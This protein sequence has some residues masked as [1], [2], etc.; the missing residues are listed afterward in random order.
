MSKYLLPILLI[1][2]ISLSCQGPKTE[3]A[4]LM[5]SLEKLPSV[6]LSINGNYSLA[7]DH[8]LVSDSGV[9]LKSIQLLQGFTSSIKTG[10]QI[11]CLE[12]PNGH[13]KYPYA[14][15]EQYLLEREGLQVTRL[16][17]I[18]QTKPGLTI[19]NFVKNVSNASV[20][21]GFQFGATSELKPSVMMDRTY[22]VNGADQ[23]IFDE[24]T[25]IFTA[26]DELNDWYAVW[27]SSADYVLAPV[28]LDCDAQASS[29][30]ASAGFEVK[31]E[32]APDQEQIVPVYIAGSDQ[33]EFAAMET[34]AELRTDLYTDWDMSFTLAD[35]LFSTSKIKVPDQEITDAYNWSKYKVGLFQFEA[36]DMI[37]SAIE[38]PDELYFL[39]KEMGSNF[40]HL[41]D[42]EVFN[43][44]ESKPRHIIPGWELFQP[45]TFYLL[46]IYG[47]I[48][49]RVTYIRPNLPSEWNDASIE[50][51]WID[52]NKLDIAIASE[53]NQMTVEITQSQ[54][55][56]GLS[57]ELPEEFSQVKVLGKEVST[58]TKDGY[59]RILMTGD[60]VRIEANKK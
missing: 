60:H 57:I 53:E 37:P 45:S 1:C 21:L 19:L 22:E 27:G 16:L 55:K 20:D 56:A 51:L 54:K 14:V 58:D 41:V 34:L 46:G 9:S 43:F 52:D 50:N 59:R 18:S 3:E 4:R 42:K 47:D 30:G 26:K 40:P 33:S 7:N 5:E 15:K 49:N 24:L 17:V 25:G 38:N 2:I 44:D 28:S 12:N 13:I 29:M 23:V 8:I 39:L 11:F 36:G 10:N 31:L 35:S 32:L 6:D 48:E